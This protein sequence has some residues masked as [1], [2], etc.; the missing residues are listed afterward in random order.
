MRSS[1]PSLAVLLTAHLA[2]AQP[3]A[4]PPLEPVAPVAPTEAGYRNWIFAATVP[5]LLLASTGNVLRNAPILELTLGAYVLGGPIVH[6][7][8]GKLGRAGASLA[9]RVGLPI[10]GLLVGDLIS[11]I[12][13]GGDPHPWN[14]FD[15]PPSLWWV[16]GTSAGFIAAGWIDGWLARPRR[17]QRPTPATS[18][19]PTVTASADRVALGIAGAF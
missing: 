3:G 10:A 13:S 4:T 9:L 16:A 5:P 1:A 14:K 18:I 6:A 8:H 2:Q 19:A 7:A 11:Q 12:A 15:G 17:P